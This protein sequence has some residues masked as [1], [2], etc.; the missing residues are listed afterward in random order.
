[1]ALPLEL[2]T[3]PLC[4]CS[5]RSPRRSRF[6]ILV[7]GLPPAPTCVCTR[8]VAKLPNKQTKSR[9]CCLACH[10]SEWWAA[11]FTPVLRSALRSHSA[12]QCGSP[13]YPRMNTRAIAAGSTM[14]IV[15]GTVA[16][17]SERASEWASEERERGGEREGETERDRERQRER[18]R[19]RDL[20]L[21]PPRS[22][23]TRRS[24]AQS[25]RSRIAAGWLR[26]S[27]STLGASVAHTH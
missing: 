16:P 8:S 6:S 12:L 5:Q 15:D 10:L 18:Q 11:C 9:P 17:R 3:E 23:T 25:D 2:F 14:S 20:W 4:P 24:R 26:L 7:I 21:G 1:M 27:V 13:E 22:A 19:E